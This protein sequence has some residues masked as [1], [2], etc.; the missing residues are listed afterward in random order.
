MTDKKYKLVPVELLD[1]FPEINASNYGHEDA[2][3]LNDWGCEVVLA[4]VAAPEQQVE[5]EPVAWISTVNCIGPDYG[6]E[7]YGKMP[8]QSLQPGYYRHTPLYTAPPAAPDVSSLVEALEVIVSDYVFCK[9]NGDIWGDR[10][11]AYVETARAALVAYWE[12][13]GGDV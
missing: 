7:R 12:Q 13:Q 11:G 5:Q 4:S 10:G 8:I 1:R 3:A 6:K 9:A 2:C